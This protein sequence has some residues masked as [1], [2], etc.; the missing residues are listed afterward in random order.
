MN[1]SIRRRTVLRLAAAVF[2]FTP[3]LS[4]AQVK[5]APGTITTIA[6]DNVQGYLGD[7]G[8]ATSAGLNLP[9]HAVFAGG[10]LYIADQFNN[11]VRFVTGGNGNI[12]TLAG[13]DG[14]A[15]NS[16]IMSNARSLFS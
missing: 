6:G 5:V 2:L 15:G 13:D 1:L 4:L 11:A 3:V 8:P 12:S 9:Y 10:N 16:S 14:V 7:G